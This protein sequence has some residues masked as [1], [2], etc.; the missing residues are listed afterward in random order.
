MS[1][2]YTQTARH[3]FCIALTEAEQQ[4]FKTHGLKKSCSGLNLYAFDYFCGVNVSGTGGMKGSQAVI[5][6]VPGT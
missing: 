1:E 5:L 4:C 3:M 2:L 6:M